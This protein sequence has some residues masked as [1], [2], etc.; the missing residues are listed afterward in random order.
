M[1]ADK[2]TRG[3]MN[4]DPEHEE[5]TDGHIVVRRDILEPL[6]PLDERHGAAHR[7][8]GQVQVSVILHLVHRLRLDREVGRHATH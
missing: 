8:A 4:L 2:D 6:A 3:N 7:H 1:R 5:L